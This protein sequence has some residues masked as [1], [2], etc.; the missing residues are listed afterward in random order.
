MFLNNGVVSALV[1]NVFVATGSEDAVIH[2]ENPMHGWDTTAYLVGGSAVYIEVP[3]EMASMQ[4]ASAQIE[5]LHGLGFHIS[6]TAPISLYASV[7]SPYTYDIATV[8]PTEVLQ[9][10]YIV[11]NYEAH[12]SNY[13]VAF[14]ATEDNTMLNMQMPCST[15]SH[16]GGSH[17]SV[18]L[19]RGW[20][21]ELAIRNDSYTTEWLN[22][23]EVTSNGKPFAMFCGL[24][25]MVCGMGPEGEDECE[26]SDMCFEQVLPVDRWGREFLLVSPA[27]KDGGDWVAITSSADNCE[28]R[29][30]C[31]SLTTLQRDSSLMLWLPP[32]TVQLLTATAPVCATLFFT[33]GAINNNIGDPSSVT[34]APLEQKTDGANFYAIATEGVTDHFVNITADASSLPYLTL[35]GQPIGHLFTPYNS[36][37]SYARLPIELGVHR[38]NSQNGG[39]SA[40]IYGLGWYE[41]YAYPVA[42]A[43]RLLQPHLVVDGSDGPQFSICQG[44]TVTLTAFSMMGDTVARWT[45]DGVAVEDSTVNLRW[46][47]NTPGQHCVTALMHGSCTVDW[48]DTVSGYINVN[49]AALTVLPDLICANPPCLWHG[50]S[51]DTTG[52]Y[53]D[54]LHTM[55]GCDSVVMQRVV[56]LIPEDIAITANRKQICVGDTVCIRVSGAEAVHW[57]SSPPDFSLEGQDYDT[58]IHI[59]PSTTTTYWIEGIDSLS[60]TIAV[61]PRLNPCVELKREYIDCDDPLVDVTDCTDDAARREWFF[62]DG[63]RYT[64]THVRRRLHQPLPDSMPILL[65]TCNKLSCC[66]DTT[67]CLPLKIQSVWFPNIFIPDN[68]D[69]G[70]GCWTSMEVDVFELV[71]FNRKGMIVWKTEDV[72]ARWDGGG[73][74]QGSYV[75]RYYIRAT[76]GLTQSGVGTVTIIR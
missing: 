22:G 52:I 32:D 7:Y 45:I 55:A 31:D 21:L 26:A 66:A 18:T 50:I 68:K 59:S 15:V 39:F 1:D 69:S 20:T 40:W 63:S 24:N 13:M 46:C 35:D 76:T 27:M 37:L 49:T 61:L 44:D 56:I 67:L 19:H 3:P 54:T 29:I 30:D 38:L 65:H 51:V 33:G 58:T 4:V 8:L 72:E 47:F 70:F 60:E 16:V 25:G 5:Q 34:L 74:P 6:S 9:T 48:C 17:Y 71:V 14:V 23:M 11:H 57:L 62:G 2:V 43:L 73:M 75:Y 64:S 41:S 53:V 36:T 12:R 42:M 10:R 28:L